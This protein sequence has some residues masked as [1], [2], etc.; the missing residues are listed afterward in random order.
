MDCESSSSDYD[1]I[2][3]TGCEDKFQSTYW[4]INY[5]RAVENET[6]QEEESENEDVMEGEPRARP[7]SRIQYSTLNISGE[8]VKE[9]YYI[10]EDEYEYEEYDSSDDQ[11]S[12]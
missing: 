11:F 2:D 1:I 7:L 5:L 8:E 6:D 4:D 9:D 12:E 10:H 3:D